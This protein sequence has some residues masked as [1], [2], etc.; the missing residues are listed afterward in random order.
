[1]DATAIAVLAAATEDTS[2]RGNSHQLAPLLHLLYTRLVEC[3]HMNP[4]WIN[5]DKILFSCGD[6]TTIQSHVLR[7]SGYD[8]DDRELELS[9]YGAEAFFNQFQITSCCGNGYKPKVVVGETGSGFVEAVGVA[10]DTQELAENFNKPGFPLI[11]AKTWVVFDESAALAADAARAAEAAVEAELN[12]LVGV[13]L[14]A[15]SATVRAYHMLGWRLLEVADLSDLASLEAAFVEALQEPNMPVVV[16]IRS[17]EGSLESDVSDNTLV[18]DFHRFGDIPVESDQSITTSLYT[19][20]AIINASRELAWNHLREGYKAF[21][22]A[23]SAALDEVTRELEECYFDEREVAGSSR[24]E[25][26]TMPLTRSKGDT[27]SRTPTFGQS[28]PR[29]LAGL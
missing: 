21:F 8:V 17:L 23:D 24:V 28:L 26:M 14:A 25:P 2:S 16:H 18:D 15:T 10:L 1:M 12:N 11:T 27:P 4:T 19:R 29:M 9:R 6:M 3:N 22:P 7:Y 13:L 5:G 20:F